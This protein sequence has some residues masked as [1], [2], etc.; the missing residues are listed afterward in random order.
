MLSP[1]SHRIYIDFPS[2]DL[3]YSIYTTYM[4]LYPNIAAAQAPQLVASIRLHKSE[5]VWPGD[6]TANTAAAPPPP[7]MLF[8]QNNS[9][10]KSD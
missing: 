8:R 3:S 1:R 4:V 6:T 5:E 7:K 2:L 9:A 10:S